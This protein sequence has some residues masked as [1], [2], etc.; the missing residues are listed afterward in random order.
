MYWY[1]MEV[2][3]K[4]SDEAS[5]FSNMQVYENIHEGFSFSVTLKADFCNNV[6]LQIVFSGGVLFHW[7]QIL[8]ACN[9]TK[10]IAAS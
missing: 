7:N 10:G 5:S 8:T 6:L 4:W 2:S 9:L 3:A 1:F